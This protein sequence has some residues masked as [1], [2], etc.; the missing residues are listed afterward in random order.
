MTLLAACA[1]PIPRSQTI[2][3]YPVKPAGTT[4]VAV[5]DYRSFIL[6]GNKEEW[7]EGIYRGAFGI[8]GSMPRND[9]F[10]RKPFTLYL[11]TKLKESIENVGGKATIVTIP[12]G[13]SLAD[14]TAAVAN[15]GADAG[16]LVMMYQSRYDTGPIDPE[17]SYYF[18]VVVLNRQGKTL[19]RKAFDG[20]EKDLEAPNIRTVFDWISVVYKR[21]FD[22]ILNDVEIKD[23]LASAAG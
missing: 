11:A 20:F 17:Y 15:A 14:A 6:S 21:I 23:A 9:E 19:V 5:V 1:T 13:T 12:K 4:A 7:F 18:D 3:V 16:L 2:P 22:K 8:P 10:E